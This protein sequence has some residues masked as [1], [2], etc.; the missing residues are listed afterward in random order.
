MKLISLVTILAGP[1]WS[2]SASFPI[3]RPGV[4]CQ[5]SLAPLKPLHFL[6]RLL[7]LWIPWVLTLTHELAIHLSP[8][9]LLLWFVCLFLLPGEG[10]NL[11]ILLPPLG[12]TVP[13]PNCSSFHAVSNCQVTWIHPALLLSHCCERTQVLSLVDLESHQQNAYKDSVPSSM[14]PN[15]R[16]KRNKTSLRTERKAMDY[17]NREVFFIYVHTEISKCFHLFARSSLERLMW[18]NSGRQFIQYYAAA[19][20]PGGMRREL[21]RWQCKNSWIVY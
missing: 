2:C 19:L 15:I 11:S 7:M 13:A 10:R 6:H 5:T 14:W 16:R 18:L 12:L 9:G 3:S 21:E 20:F 1:C 17:T 4:P 8:Q